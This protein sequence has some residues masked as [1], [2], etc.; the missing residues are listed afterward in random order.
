MN[1]ITARILSIQW[2]TGLSDD[3]IDVLATWNGKR[4]E[5]G[6]DDDLS[7][8]MQH[9]H[10]ISLQE[11]MNEFV[12]ASLL[13]E[14][15]QAERPVHL[16][17]E[18]V[19][20]LSADTSLVRWSDRLGFIERAP[21]HFDPIRHALEIYLTDPLETRESLITTINGF[22]TNRRP[23][24]TYLGQGNAARVGQG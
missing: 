2:L 20:G 24:R 12:F 22:Y 5:L 6:L 4:H 7:F 1:S 18:A 17:M 14:L 10:G 16:T 19:G 3:D 15:T 13:L 11:R 23:R 8:F 21:K 9:G